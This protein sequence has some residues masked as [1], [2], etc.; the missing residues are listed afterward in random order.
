VLVAAIVL[1]ARVA[2]DV[3]GVALPHVG[4]VTPDEEVSSVAE[5]APQTEAVTE[6]EQRNP[7]TD[8]PT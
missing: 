7:P 4:H 6:I 2:F 1:R 3:L 5:Q 8:R